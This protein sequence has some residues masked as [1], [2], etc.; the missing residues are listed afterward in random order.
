MINS[1]VLTLE[2]NDILQFLEWNDQLQDSEWNDLHYSS[3]WSGTYQLWTL[4]W[5]DVLNSRFRSGLINSG[6]RSRMI[7]LHQ[8]LE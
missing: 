8:S 3:L 5:I 4:K 2:W 7:Y 6:H 1:G